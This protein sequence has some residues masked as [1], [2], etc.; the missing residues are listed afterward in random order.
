[1]LGELKGHLDRK[2]ESCITRV[3]EK[4][5]AVLSLDELKTR[6]QESWIPAV[7]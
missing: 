6:I 5:W 1:M 4:E 2:T 3:I 7:D